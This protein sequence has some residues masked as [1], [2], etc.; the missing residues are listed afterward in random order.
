MT[1]QGEVPAKFC[2]ELCTDLTAPN[3]IYMYRSDVET[4]LL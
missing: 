1:W 3:R 4:P 2:T